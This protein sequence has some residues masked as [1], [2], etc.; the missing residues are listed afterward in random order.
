MGKE[1]MKWWAVNLCQ[2]GTIDISGS[3]KCFSP[4]NSQDWGGAGPVP[5]AFLKKPQ[6]FSSSITD[7]QKIH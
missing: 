7:V 4:N 6:L 5:C 2:Y 1:V 3:Q